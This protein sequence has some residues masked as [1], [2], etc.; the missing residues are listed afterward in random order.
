MPRLKEV[1]GI[2]SL[3]FTHRDNAIPEP[4]QQRQKKAKLCIN[5]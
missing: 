2:V 1:H 4:P 3:L 5:T